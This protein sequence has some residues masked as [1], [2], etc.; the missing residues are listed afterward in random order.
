MQTSSERSGPL[1]LAF[2]VNPPATPSRKRKAT[3][4]HPRPGA[5]PRTRNILE[6]EK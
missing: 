4:S 6:S 5:A 1:Q 3:S 2:D